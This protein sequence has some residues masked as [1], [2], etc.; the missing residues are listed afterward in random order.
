MNIDEHSGMG[1]TVSDFKEVWVLVIFF[2]ADAIAA[3]PSLN[4]WLVTNFGLTRANPLGIVM[5]IVVYD[6]WA[7]VVVLFLASVAYV[8][9]TMGLSQPARRQAS[10]LYLLLTLTSAIVGG[11]AWYLTGLYPAIPVHGTSGVVM[12]AIGMTYPPTGMAMGLLVLRYRKL[13]GADRAAKRSWFRRNGFAPYWGFV[14]NLV[15]L[16][17]AFFAVIF[18]TG[19]EIVHGVSFTVAML[20]SLGYY[21]TVYRNAK[22]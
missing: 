15:C 10:R 3:I 12:A 17:V 7:N 11:L 8:L 4:A 22:V 14:L 13:R 18:V 6:G 1:R 5:S 2:A 20:V 19:N 16:A 9:G 21:F